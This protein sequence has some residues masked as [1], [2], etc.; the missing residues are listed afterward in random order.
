MNDCK[1]KENFLQ[2]NMIVSQC[3]NQK[4]EKRFSSLLLAAKNGHLETVKW[5]FENGCDINERNESL[6]LA[7]SNGHL[8]L[9]IHL[10]TW[11]TIF[12]I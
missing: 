5:L 2:S 8:D 10:C 4:N 3:L 6:F 7:A 12:T 1:G 9:I 11:V